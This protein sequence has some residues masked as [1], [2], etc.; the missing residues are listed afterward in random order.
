MAAL[1]VSSAPLFKEFERESQRKQARADL[2]RMGEK[3][4]RSPAASQTASKIANMKDLDRLNELMDGV[5]DVNA[6]PELFAS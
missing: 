1:D 4:F 3:K 5:L 2:P 6:W